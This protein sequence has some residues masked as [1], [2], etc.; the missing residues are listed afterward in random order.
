MTYCLFIL[1]GVLHV[2]LTFP[3]VIWSVEEI[4]L[5]CQHHHVHLRPKH[6]DVGE[7]FPHRLWELGFVLRQ[8]LKIGSDGLQ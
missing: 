2:G 1:G 8:Q 6:I 7:P 5:F 4:I 3:Y